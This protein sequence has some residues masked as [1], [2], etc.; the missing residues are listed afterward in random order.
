MNFGIPFLAA[1]QAQKYV[2][3]NEAFN[4][5]D[6][7]LNL[8]VIRADFTNPPV[9]PSEGDKYIPFA[10]AGGEWTGRENQ[11]AV[12]VNAEWVFFV[13]TIGLT[14][15]NQALGQ[16]IAYNG[17]AWVSYALYAGLTPQTENG[18]VTTT[19]LGISAND[20]EFTFVQKEEL[21]NFSSGAI[22]TSSLTFPNR[23]V[24]LFASL[25][26]VSGITGPTGVQWY[27]E[28]FGSVAIVFETGFSGNT[29]VS[30]QQSGPANPMKPVFSSAP[31]SFEDFGVTAG[32]G[33][34]SAFTGGSARLTIG[35]FESQPASS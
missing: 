14:A 15:F 28:E 17:S 35:Y 13:P 30:Q 20:A 34:G 16:Y 5:I 4:V 33:T 2:T 8:D 24:P 31:V 29:S 23:S 19:S 32:S 11:I 21:V 1:G 3:V 10:P 12:Y 27:V 9:G 7:A 22:V 6:Q 26:N 18:G 25:Y